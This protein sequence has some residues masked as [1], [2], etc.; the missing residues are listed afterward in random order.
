M[1]LGIDPGT[2]MSGYAVVDLNYNVRSADKVPNDNLLNMLKTKPLG[3]TVVIESMSCYGAPVGRE[4]FETSYFIGRIQQIC[5]DNGLA[6]YLYPRPEYARSIAGVKKVTDAVLRQALL[7]RF[8]GDTKG[9]PL[10]LLKGASDK[11]SAY[12][13]CVYW[14]DMQRLK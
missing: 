10:Y 2:E 4:V 8:G 14:L 13:L 3:T 12:A 6:Y 7:L 5:D 1:I 9:E 11:R